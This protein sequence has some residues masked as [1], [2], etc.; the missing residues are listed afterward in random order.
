MSGLQIKYLELFSLS[1]RPLFYENQVCRKFTTT[2]L[3]DLIIEPTPEC[4]EIMGRLDMVYRTIAG[5]GRFIVL[6][7]IR[8]NS[9]G[10]NALRFP[11]RNGDKLS[12]RMTVQH[13]EWFNFNDLPVQQDPSRIYYFSN[14]LSDGGAPR[15]NLHISAAATGVSGAHDLVKSSTSNYQFHHTGVVTPGTAA[16]KHLLTGI[17]VSPKNIVTQSGQSDLYFDLSALPSGKC[18][19]LINAAEKDRF[20]YTGAAAP[21][22]L[23]GI[24]EISLSALLDANYRTVEVDDVLA[25]ARPLYTLQFNNRK[26]FWRYTIVMEKHNPLYLA[27]LAMT[28]AEKNTFLDHF[29]IVTNDAAI[30]FTQVSVNDT[31]F[32]FLSDNV[33]A[34]QEKYL[35]SSVAGKGL[36][37]TLKKNAGIAGDAVVR[38]YLPFP[39]TGSIDALN[40]PTI[41]SDIFL[42][43]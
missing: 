30:S 14:Q 34:L 16:V 11:V 39:S 29:K 3:P 33:V 38:D 4:R 21:G 7:H 2:P 17:L 37:L 27:M 20:Y 6:S 43:I 8:V 42:T 10:D 36:R 25:P 13:P 19:L 23:F 15:D 41:Y 9:G 40:D 31:V 18:T 5:Q 12:F 35:S 32:E 1:V 22:P 26:T 24:I 28:P